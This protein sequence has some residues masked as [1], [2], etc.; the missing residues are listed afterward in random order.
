MEVLMSKEITLKRR[1]VTLSVILVLVFSFL[2][3]YSLLYGV[4]ADT[5]MDR[6]TTNIPDTDIGGATGGMGT[7]SSPI[8]SGTG[9]GSVGESDLTT[10]LDT[11]PRVTTARQTTAPQTTQNAPNTSDGNGWIVAVIV[12]AVI[13]AIIIAII[14]L[15]PKKRDL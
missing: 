2:A 13:A 6:V 10:P 3:M 5:T 8:A 9:S 4:Y 15:M 12:I 7:D 11:T 14:A 1:T